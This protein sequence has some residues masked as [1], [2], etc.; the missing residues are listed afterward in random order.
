MT[1][2]EQ[3]TRELLHVISDVPLTFIFDGDTYTDGATMGS[4]VT[5]KD[6]TEGGFLGEPDLTITTTLKVLNSSDA[7]VNRFTTAPEPQDLVTVSGTVYRIQ[8]TTE[9]EIS[10]ALVLDLVSKSV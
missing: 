3:D 7:L 4:L 5:T 2:A 9:D 10:S 6:L 8:S 1:F